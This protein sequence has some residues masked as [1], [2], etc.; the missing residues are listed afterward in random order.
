MTVS[1]FD[2]KTMVELPYSESSEIKYNFQDV[3]LYNLAVGC[4]D[5]QFMHEKHPNF[6]VFPTFPIRFAGSGAWER[7]PRTTPGLNIDGER[8]MELLAPLPV[9]KSRK[10]TVSVFA[11]A[12]VCGLHDKKT[13]ALCEFETLIKDKD[14]KDLVK[15]INGEFY[16]GIKK[17]GD[18]GPFPSYGKTY[19]ESVP[20]PKRMPDMNVRLEIPNN[21][22]HIY[23][24]S[25][26]Y[27]PHHID[28]AAA[29]LVGYDRVILHGLC[30]LGR[31]TSAL[32]TTLCSNQVNR[33]KR[34]KMRFS[35]PV[36]MGEQLNIQIW[37]DG[38]GRV[39][40][41]VV[42]RERNE[43]CVSHAYFEFKVDAKM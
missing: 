8:Y 6:S 19:S 14:G 37:Y 23:R 21:A 32:L 33:F 34:V 30:T 10:D 43:I 28:P 18:I 26:D 39:I 24:L 25:G 29:K 42:P 12:K 11:S 9:P 1:M 16:R 5:L 17:L 15:L 22:A 38:P 27:L 36:Y 13:G 31:V 35:A 4:T 40:F 20:P 3:L 7:F 2:A 41:Q